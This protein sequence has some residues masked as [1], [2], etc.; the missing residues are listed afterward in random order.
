M[1]YSLLKSYLNHSEAAYTRKKLIAIALPAIAE[2]ILQMLLGVADTAFL[3]HYD[4]KVMTGVGVA[5]QVMF[6]F[7]AVLIA[8]ATGATVY[9]S[10]GLGA[11]NKKLVDSIAWH[12]L[13]LSVA[14]GFGLTIFQGFS[15]GLLNIFFPG[16][17]QIM[18][19]NGNEYLK[20]VLQGSIGLSAM[21]IIGATLR[22][23]GDTTAPM[24]TALFAN[25]LNIFLDYTMIFGKLGFPE[26]GARGAALATIISRFFGT[27]LLLFFLFRNKNISMKR[28][29]SRPSRRITREI[30]RVGIPSGLENLSFSVGVMIFANILLM[31]GS[32]AYAA[33]RIGIQIE[34]LSF[35]PAYGIQIAIMTLVG[36]Y[37]GSND[38][39]LAMGSVRQGWILA[40][41]FAIVIGGSIFAFPRIFIGIFTN[42]L[43]IIEMAVLPVRLIG[44]LQIVLATDFVST[45]ALRGLGDTRYPMYASMIAMWAIRIP[46]G[47]VLV[48]FFGLGL[49]GAWIG[50]MIDMIFRC[51]I[52]LVRFLSGRWESKA[53][54]LRRA[55]NKL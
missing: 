22:G 7:Q 6:I 53:A 1:K 27:G 3:G 2:N 21:M 51:I 12:A 33:H 28:Y 40:M 4:W 13:Y 14:I 36:M 41:V 45:G 8:V 10:N 29:P 55:A 17:E 44:L 9:I 20:I 23:A 48:K 52:K 16:A 11:R 38:L 25:G 37:N 15:G 18:L 24:L 31:A 26:M 46:V 35:M 43:S 47:F 5:N 50:M 54:Y 42:E 19:S 49:L 32:Q 30:F 39:K 34:S